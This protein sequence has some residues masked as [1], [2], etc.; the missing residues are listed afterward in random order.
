[1]ATLANMR[2]IF[3]T[4]QGWP[5]TR[6]VPLPNYENVEKK[7]E[8]EKKKRKKKKK[9]IQKVKKSEKKKSF[10]ELNHRIF[11]FGNWQQ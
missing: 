3:E 7:K 5:W 4:R 8:K 10:V 9:K 1:M 6:L 11:F 2:W